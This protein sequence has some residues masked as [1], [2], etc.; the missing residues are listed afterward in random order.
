[1]AAEIQAPFD[2]RPQCGDCSGRRRA[3]RRVQRMD[4]PV[5]IAQRTLADLTVR[6][7]RLER[8]DVRGMEMPIDVVGQAR[9][10]SVML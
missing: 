9:G 10:P 7:V 1:M 4:D 8:F 5:E 2:S 6:N 3:T